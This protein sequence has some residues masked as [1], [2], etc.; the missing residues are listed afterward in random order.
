MVPDLHDSVDACLLKSP[1]P[2]EEHSAREASPARIPAGKNW[3]RSP[4]SKPNVSEQSDSDDDNVL[5]N[6]NTEVSEKDE[7]VSGSQEG[8]LSLIRSHGV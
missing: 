5:P 3:L 6:S 8:C 2:D 1:S 4:H 7:E